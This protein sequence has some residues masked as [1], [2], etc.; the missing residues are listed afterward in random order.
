MELCVKAILEAMCQGI[1]QMHREGTTLG[2]AERQAWQRVKNKG[3]DLSDPARGG[4]YAVFDQR[5]LSR[6]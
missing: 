3:R 5:P 1:G 6:T 4:I 2:Y